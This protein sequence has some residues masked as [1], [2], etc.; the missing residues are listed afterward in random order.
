MARVVDGV[1]AQSGC[2]AVIDFGSGLGHLVR[3]LAYKYDL[4]TAGIECQVQLTEEARSVLLV[5]MY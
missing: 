4:Y 1:A 5:C 3:M 2:E